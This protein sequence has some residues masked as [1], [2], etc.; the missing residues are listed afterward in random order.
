MFLGAFTIPLAKHVGPR[1][2]VLAIEPARLNFQALCAN[3]ALNSLNNVHT[4]HAGVGASRTKMTMGEQQGWGEP[5]NQGDVRLHK[6]DHKSATEV[7]V[8]V[9]TVDLLLADSPSNL[10][11]TLLKVNVQ[12][13]KLEVV[14][15]AHGL[16][17]S[18]KPP[19]VYIE[20][21]FSRT[22]CLYICSS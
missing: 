21:D 7:S 11:I 9:T 3:V 4:Y 15:G 22:L 8:P 19:F 17:T 10:H 2:R 14:Q 12:G 5:G 20:N 16:L 13:M 18:R 6:G 1:G